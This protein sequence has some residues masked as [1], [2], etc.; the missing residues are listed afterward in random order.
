MTDD[1]STVSSADESMENIGILSH[2]PGLESFKDHFKYRVRRY[3]DLLNLL[4]KHEGG[5]DEFARG[6]CLNHIEHCLLLS[7]SLIITAMT[8]FALLQCYYP[9]L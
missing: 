9:F 7:Y 3:A 1:T 5:L 6:A 8:S 4:D 2:D